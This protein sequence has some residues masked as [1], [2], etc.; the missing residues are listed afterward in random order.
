MIEGKHYAISAILFIGLAAMLSISN[1]Y[2]LGVNI[3]YALS[4]LLYLFL[5][6][7]FIYWVFK[8]LRKPL[9]QKP[10]VTVF[11]ILLLLFLFSQVNM[12]SD[13]N[14]SAREEAF[15]DNCEQK[16]RSQVKDNPSLMDYDLHAYCS[17]AAQRSKKIKMKDTAELSD[18]RSAAFMELYGPCWESAKLKDS[19]IGISAEMGAD[20]IT[21][22]NLSGHIQVKTKVNGKEVYMIFDSGASDLFISREFLDQF[23]SGQVEYLEEYSYYNM[24]DG[25]QIKAQQA[26]IQR[27][28][29]G[30]FKIKG[31]KVAVAEEVV[32]PLLGKSILDQF[33]SWTINSDNQ[34]ILV[35]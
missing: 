5:L 35:P 24:A 29:L 33:S 15:I 13:L 6:T 20:T 11:Y 21:V 30:K 10:K 3:G 19:L 31:L 32:N 17:C 2:A 25:T 18:P 27:F 7:S 12:I 8:V 23:S 28:E 4:F 9:G 1:G 22:I 34:L 16:L 26:K 14:R